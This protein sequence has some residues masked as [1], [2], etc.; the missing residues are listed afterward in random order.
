MCHVDTI[1]GHT[2]W[3]SSMVCMCVCLHVLCLYLNVSCVYVLVCIY[4]VCISVCVYV[5][6]CASNVGQY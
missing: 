5:Y 3:A 2:L 6:V 1:L 4:F